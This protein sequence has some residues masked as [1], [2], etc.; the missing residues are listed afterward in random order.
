MTL[1]QLVYNWPWVVL[2]VL[3]CLAL[4]ALVLLAT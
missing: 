4:A 1:V 2:L 3:A